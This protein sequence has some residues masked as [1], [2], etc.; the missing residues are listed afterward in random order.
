MFAF[1]ETVTR[2]RGTP[3][4]DPYS[5]EATDLDWTSPDALP[6]PGCG[7]APSG[8]AEPL[9]QGRNAVI[10]TPTVYAPAGADVL[11]HDRLIVRGRT[12]Q[13]KGDPA[14]WR[15]PMTGWTPG[16]VIQLEE[17]AG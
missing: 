12:W 8:S 13:V 11:A 15:H 14:D 5:I 1:G 17:V 9:E 4:T 10:T 3:V 7:F 16:L 2:L 6:I